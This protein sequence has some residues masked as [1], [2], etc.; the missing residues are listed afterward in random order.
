MRFCFTLLFLIVGLS[1]C[2]Q[3]TEQQADAKC[4]AFLDYSDKLSIHTSELVELH[5]LKMA[6]IKNGDQEAV[7]KYDLMIAENSAE[8]SKLKA[9]SEGLNCGGV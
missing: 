9:Q 7:E 5:E 3:T 1:A 2:G 8:M 4:D 6:A